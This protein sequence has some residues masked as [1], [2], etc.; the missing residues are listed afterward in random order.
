MATI[1]IRTPDKNT[2][3]FPRRL[4]RAAQL[5]ARMKDGFSPEIVNDM[6]EFLSEYIEGDKKQ[7]I[8]N[9][10]DCTE[11]NFNDL[12]SAVTGGSPEEIP[13]P[14]LEPTDTPL[15]GGI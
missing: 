3:G 1:S 8:E 14:K 2:P 4:Y 12:I 9:L 5:Q 13:P 7:A 15:T 11:S 10:W 6:I